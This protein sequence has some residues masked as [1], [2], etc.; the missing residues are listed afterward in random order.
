MKNRLGF[1]ISCTLIACWLALL[2]CSGGPNNPTIKGQVLL[3]GQPL[4]GARVFFQ[5]G[6]KAGN[7]AVTNEDGKF[8]FDASHPQNTLK[9]GMYKVTITK[10]VDV[11]TGQAPPAGD[12]E[13]LAASGN[14]KNSLPPIYAQPQTTPL[15]AEIKQGPNELKAFELK[16]Q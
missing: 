7:G 13:M 15:S 10:L 9:P 11:K 8:A 14:A 16:K 6:D 2:G 12:E 4:A 5:G 3:D 1:Q